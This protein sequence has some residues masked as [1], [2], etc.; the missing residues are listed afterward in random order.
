MPFTEGI[1]SKSVKPPS[2]HREQFS[3]PFKMRD[4]PYQ[5]VFI[6]QGSVGKQVVVSPHDESIAQTAYHPMN[7]CNLTAVSVYP[8]IDHDIA[9]P[10]LRQ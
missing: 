9:R 3:V 8:P 2:M 10:K 4:H 7:P 6:H 5:I 1:L